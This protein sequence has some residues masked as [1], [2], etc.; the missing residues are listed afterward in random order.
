MNYKGQFIIWGP[1]GT[2]K[3]TRLARSVEKI[4]AQ[5]NR[6]LPAMVC[7]LTR[8]AAV[9]AARRKMSIP[10]DAVGTLH[11]HAYAAIGRPKVVAKCVGD[12]NER[13]K[14]WALTQTMWK[15]NADPYAERARGRGDELLNHLQLLRARMTPPALWPLKI[16]QFAAKWERWKQDAGIID[17]VDMIERAIQE[18]DRA[19][20]DPGVILVDE[21]QDHDALEMTLLRKWGKA[22][23]ALIVTGDPDQCLYGWRGADPAMFLDSSIPTDHRQVLAQSWRVPRAV[24]AVAMVLRAKIENTL[25][26]DYRP[27]DADGSIGHSAATWARPELMLTD[28]LESV[29]AGRSVMVAASC[30]FMLNPLLA[31]LRRGGHPFCNPWRVERGDWNPLRTGGKGTSTT[32]RLIAFLSPLLDERPSVSDDGTDFNFGANVREYPGWPAK[33][34]WRWI[35]PL[36]AKGILRRGARG[37]IEAAAGHD[38]GSLSYLPVVREQIE[39][40]FEPEAA[41]AVLAVMEGRIDIA[42]ATKW[43]VASAQTARR[44]PME[45]AARVLTTHGVKVLRERPRL[46]VGT[47]HSFKGAEADEVWLF[48]DLSPAGYRDWCGANQDAILRM[49]YVGL[50]RARE[51]VVLCERATDSSVNLP[52]LCG[53]DA[54]RKDKG[55]NNA[56]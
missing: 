24:H 40:W 50:T 43:W 13:H 7:S 11:H 38:T 41:A 36:R 26:I 27:R 39:R 51:R 55:E 5:S 21:A 37:E 6:E 48:P 4:C 2:G 54:A 46:Y 31:L 56:N 35:E 17:F 9:E 32:D 45:Y 52:W 14:D 10:A 22:A 3:T 28:V 47:I 34:A 23:D 49:F 30:G 1:P 33:L 12:W 8:G 15:E 53:L 44:R 19:P 42:R 25:A 29:Q 16:Q 18:S 20:G